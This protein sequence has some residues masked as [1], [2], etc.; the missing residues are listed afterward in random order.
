MEYCMCKYECEYEC[1]RWCENLLTSH[2]T[3]LYTLVER[4]PRQWCP[5]GTYWGGGEQ[6]ECKKIQRRAALQSFT[7]MRRAINRV[8]STRV[9]CGYETT[10]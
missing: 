3:V 6:E 9:W 5:R 10:K 7:A 4:C 1:V 2:T 8:Y